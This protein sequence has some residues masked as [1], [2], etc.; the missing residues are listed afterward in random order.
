MPPGSMRGPDCCITH[1]LVIIYVRIWN[2]HKLIR[3]MFG[4]LLLVVFSVVVCAVANPP[5]EKPLD[6]TVQAETGKVEAKEHFG[7]RRQGSRY[8]G[9]PK[10]RILG[11]GPSALIDN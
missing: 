6:G 10:R 3:R 2:D 4:P 5:Q 9:G 7:Y 11:S 8:S 1:C